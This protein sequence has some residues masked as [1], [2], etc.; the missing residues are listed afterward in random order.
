[1]LFV[2]SENNH[3]LLEGLARSLVLQRAQVLARNVAENTRVGQPLLERFI[4][5]LVGRIE[6]R[7]LLPEQH[8]TK[9]APGLCPRTVERIC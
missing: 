5:R 9:I 7:R 1:M 2:A 6:L 4:H 3:F 8:Q